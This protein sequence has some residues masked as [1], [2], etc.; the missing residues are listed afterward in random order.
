MLYLEVDTNSLRVTT[1]IFI[2]ISPF[3]LVKG[4]VYMWFMR[5]WGNPKSYIREAHTQIPLPDTDTQSYFDLR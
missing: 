1:V 3:L 2:S 4:H 5:K